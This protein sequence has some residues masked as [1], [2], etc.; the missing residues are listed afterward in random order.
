MRDCKQRTARSRPGN[1]GQMKTAAAPIDRTGEFRSRNQAR[2]ISGT[3]RP[4]EG[5]GCSG[6]EQAKVDPGNGGLIPG[7]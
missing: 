4:Q 3:A 7:D 6:Y 2:E 5:S 1:G